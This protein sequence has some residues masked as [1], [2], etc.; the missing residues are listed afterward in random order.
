L[1]RTSSDMRHVAV[2]LKPGFIDG[3]KNKSILHFGR[4]RR[5]ESLAALLSPFFSANLPIIDYFG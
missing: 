5:S 1:N 3:Q 2:Y 4:Q